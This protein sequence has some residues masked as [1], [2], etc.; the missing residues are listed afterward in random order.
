MKVTM[1]W[2]GGSSYA[3]FDTHNPRDAEEFDSMRAARNAFAARTNDSYYPCVDEESPD[4]GGPEAWI[5]K[6]PAKQN[7]G[8]EYPDFTMSFGP[9]G[10]VRVTRA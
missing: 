4:D 2:F 5:F 6:G 3:M 8:A 9:R 10:G 7:I 1:F